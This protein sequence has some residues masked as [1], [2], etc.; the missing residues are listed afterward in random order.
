M[1]GV[2]NSLWGVYRRKS[3]WKVAPVGGFRAPEDPCSQA[4][5]GIL[6][7]PPGPSLS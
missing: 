3:I 1:G 7:G 2:H 4:T 5:R 6:H